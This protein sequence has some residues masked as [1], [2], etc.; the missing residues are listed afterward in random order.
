[1][2]P[3]AVA[4]V[5]ASTVAGEEYRR[6]LRT[7]AGNW[8]LIARLPVLLDPVNNPVFFAWLSH[9]FL[10]LVVPWAL[11]VALLASA[12]AG[13]TFFRAALVLQLA[14]Y[15]IAVAALA[16]PALAQRV[17]LLP[18]AGTF[19]MLNVAALMSLPAALALDPTRLWKKH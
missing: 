15:G 8:Q 7:L 12:L 19:L 10:R 2:A 11:L 4:H 16:L 14:A 18:A 6:K 1:M 9:K 3:K 5:Q 17:P 13:G